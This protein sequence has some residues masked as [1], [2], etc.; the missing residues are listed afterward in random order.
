MF[1]ESREVREASAN[2]Q[3]LVDKNEIWSSF[4]RIVIYFLAYIAI[5]I[6]SIIA[7]YQPRVLNKIIFHLKGIGVNI[8]GISGWTKHLEIWPQL[9]FS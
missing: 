2:I 3:A 8:K 4:L 1:F 6:H 9:M 7:G 5:K